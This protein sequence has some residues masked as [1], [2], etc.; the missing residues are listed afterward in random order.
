M[1]STPIH[2]AFVG[3]IMPSGVLY[4]KNELN[5][6]S[7]IITELNN[8]DLRVGNLECALSPYTEHPHLDPEK[9][10][11]L[12][13]YVWAID[14]DMQRVVKMGFDVLCLA[15][16]HVYDLNKEGLQYT[17]AY[18]DQLGIK[19]CGAGMNLEQASEPAILNIK[20]K[21]IAI[22]SC[23]EEIEQTG[24]YTPFAT[25]NHAGVYPLYPADRICTQIQQLKTQ[26]DYVFIAPHWG[27]ENTWRVNEKVFET[28]KILIDAGAD[29]IIGS[30]T[31]RVQPIVWHHGKPIFPSLG[32]FFFVD[33]YLNKPRPTW[34]PP[35]GT[36]TSRYPVVGGYPWVE[37]PTIKISSEENRIGMIGYVHLGKQI[38]I[39]K[40]FVQLGKDNFLRKLPHAYFYFLKRKYRRLYLWKLLYTIPF[41]KQLIL[42]K[43]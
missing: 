30:H 15:N 22:I 19:Y 12:M 36:D 14:E 40:T 6:S 20:G 21:Q 26:C 24:D 5:V 18:L 41:I 28:A 43:R 27:T 4:G 38:S 42:R 37:E 7:E 10:H 39:S 29:G 35:K 34:Y 32:N 13:D 31:H 11:R 17:L 9:L 33:R 23:C 16:N 1:T 25:E 8:V 2:I 3:D